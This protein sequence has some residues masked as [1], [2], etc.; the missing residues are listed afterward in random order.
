M[1]VEPVWFPYATY[2]EDGFVNGIS[3][4]APDSAKEA[5]REYVERNR[6][7]EQSGGMIPR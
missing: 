7:I 5:Y 6:A 2:D 4:D 1:D 3:D